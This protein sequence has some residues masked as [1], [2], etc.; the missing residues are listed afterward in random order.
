VLKFF[1]QYNKYILVIGGSILIETVF[2]WPG[3]G[4]MM[5]RAIQARDFPLVQGGV[6]FIATVFVFINLI[7]DI[8]YAYLDPRIRYT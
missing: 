8:A 6:L 5:V 1:R 4:L 3:L 7:V 2:T